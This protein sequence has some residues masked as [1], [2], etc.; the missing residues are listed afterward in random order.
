[1]CTKKRV[2]VVSIYKEHLELSMNN[3]CMF[4]LMFSTGYS[5]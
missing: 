5:V 2:I 3:N 4:F 1:M